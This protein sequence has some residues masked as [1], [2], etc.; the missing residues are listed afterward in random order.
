M[1]FYFFMFFIYFLMFLCFLMLCYVVKT[2]K[3]K[4]TNMTLFL[5][6]KLLLALFSICT[7]IITV[8]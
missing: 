2:A 7:I 6:R 8:T 3:D 5:M 4:I 1:F